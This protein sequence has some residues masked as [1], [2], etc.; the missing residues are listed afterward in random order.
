L[1]GIAMLAATAASRT[2]APRSMGTDVVVAL[3]LLGFA[4]ARASVSHAGENGL[5]SLAF[6]VEWLH[7][8]LIALWFG[9]V[10]IGGWIVLPQAHPQGRERLPVNRYLALLSHA[11][12]VALIGIVAT[13]LYN[14]WQRVGSVQNLSGNV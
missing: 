7:L 9:G 11:A 6:G 8:V 2:W 5:A 4:A 3:L 12:T 10:A 14:A 13:G 1:A